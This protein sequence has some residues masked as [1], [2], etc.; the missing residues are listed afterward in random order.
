M[1]SASVLF[2]I[3]LTM[4]LGALPAPVSAQM[5][6]ISPVYVAV[7][8]VFYLCPYLVREAKAP[9]ASGLAKWGFEVSAEGRPGELSFKGTSEKGFL[10]A[11]F[12]PTKKRCT[13]TY[14]GGGYEQISGAVRDTVIGNKFTRVTGG[15]KDGAKAD[16]FEGTVPKSSAT[17]RIII[18]ENYTNKS[19]S[20]AYSER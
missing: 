2:G 7:Y 9:S 19:S 20:I 17:A 8:G 5:G 14:A 6:P 3:T 10:V 1:K 18:I 11:S 16:V 4:L 13:V 15:D 12:D